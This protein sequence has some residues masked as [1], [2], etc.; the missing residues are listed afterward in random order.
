MTFLIISGI[1]ENR[2]SFS[3]KEVK[4]GAGRDSGA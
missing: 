2:M 3:E 1:S 4:E